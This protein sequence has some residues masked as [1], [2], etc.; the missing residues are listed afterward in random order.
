MVIFVLIRKEP[1]EYFDRLGGNDR[2]NYLALD[3]NAMVI[4]LNL[5]NQIVKSEGQI[6]AYIQC[7]SGPGG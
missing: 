3:M 5:L 1:T 7:Y 2:Y 4:I 6:Y